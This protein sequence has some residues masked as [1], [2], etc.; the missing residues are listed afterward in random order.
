M[1]QQGTKMGP[2]T[3]LNKPIGVDD[4]DDVE[5][6]KLENDADVVSLAN[7]EDES[8]AAAGHPL[9]AV[10]VCGNFSFDVYLS[11]GTSVSFPCII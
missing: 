9:A 2:F 4:D 10:Q 6:L 11:T 8:K 7:L 5:N 1:Q 3:P